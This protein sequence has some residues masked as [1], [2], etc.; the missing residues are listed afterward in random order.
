MNS[1]HSV[2]KMRSRMRPGS[3]DSE[4][5]QTRISS[6]QGFPVPLFPSIT[7]EE[8]SSAAVCL[9]FSSLDN[10]APEIDDHVGTY[11]ARI[12]PMTVAMC[13]RNAIRL[14][15]NFHLEDARL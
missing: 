3:L 13:L 9:N 14:Y 6:L 10:F 4:R 1:A 15:Q 11:I 12:G 7:P 5:L 2:L 8:V